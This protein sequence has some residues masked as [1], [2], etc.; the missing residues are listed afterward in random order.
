[1]VQLSPSKGPPRIWSSLPWDRIDGSSVLRWGQPDSGEGCIVLQRG[2]TCSLVVKFLHVQSS[3]AVREFCANKATDGC[4]RT[5][6]A[7][8]CSA[9]S[10]TELSKLCELRWPTFEFTMQE[11]S[12]VGGY[13]ENLE[14]PQ[15]CQN[16]GVGACAD[17]GTCPGQY[18][19]RTWMAR[20]T[21][22]PEGSGSLA[23]LQLLH[24]LLRLRSG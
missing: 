4:V 7:W 8:C 10:I 3:L 9:L 2:P 14:K 24:E 19:L 15:N 13:T 17:M 21:L 11:F 12:M 20:I 22:A 6:D 18:C 1:M 16:W 23:K 5:F